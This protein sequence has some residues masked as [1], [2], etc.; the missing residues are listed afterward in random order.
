MELRGPIFNRKYLEG[1][2]LVQPYERPGIELKLRPAS[3]RDPDLITLA[4]RRV[5][6]GKAPLLCI[7]R[8]YLNVSFDMAHPHIAGTLSKGVRE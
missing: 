4:K 7:S 3:L 2:I 8:M 6:R 1:R 5:Q